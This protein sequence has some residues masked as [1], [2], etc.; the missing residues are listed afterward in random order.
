[1]ARILLIEDDQYVRTM[2]RLLLLHHGHTVVEAC[3][4]H[5]G[6]KLFPMPE[7]TWSSPTM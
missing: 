1:M 4:G 2:L 6:L 5:A 7:P 3:N